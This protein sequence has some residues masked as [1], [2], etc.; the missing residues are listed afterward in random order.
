LIINR[1]EGLLAAGLTLLRA[2]YCS[3]PD[4]DLF[5]ILQDFEGVTVRD[6]ND[7]ALE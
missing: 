4:L 1:P 7:L 3:K 2:I 5:A 6:T